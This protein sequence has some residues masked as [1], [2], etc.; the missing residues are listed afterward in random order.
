MKVDEKYKKK[1]K[2][3]LLATT[4]I[5]IKGIYPCSTYVKVIKPTSKEVPTFNN[6][7]DGKRPISESF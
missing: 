7:K 5:N 4:L 3:L 2:D 1:L 6:L